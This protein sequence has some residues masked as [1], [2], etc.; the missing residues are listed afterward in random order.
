MHSSEDDKKHYKRVESPEPGMMVA[1]IRPFGY[2]RRILAV[3]LRPDPRDNFYWN[4][5][6]ERG[7]IHTAL[8]VDFFYPEKVEKTT[9]EQLLDDLIETIE[10]YTPKELDALLEERKKSNGS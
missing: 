9:E 3:L 7:M 4:I 2:N 10:G 5:L 1:W 6:D 8:S